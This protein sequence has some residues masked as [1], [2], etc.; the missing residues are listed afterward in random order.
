[1][2]TLALLAACLLPCPFAA[3][4]GGGFTAG[5]LYLFSPAIQGASTAD[6]A[7]VHVDLSAGT[8]TILVDTFTTPSSMGVM[9]FDPWRQ[10]LI[11]RAGLDSVFDPVRLWAVDAAGN[12]DDLGFSG[13]AWSMFAPT[14]D[15]RIYLRNNTGT[16][17]TQPILYL[18]AAN[19]L[20]VL[21]DSTGTAPFLVDGNGAFDIRGIHYD[22]PTNS[23]FISSIAAVGACA[24][25]ATDKLNLRKLPLSADGTR[26]VG[27]VTCVQFEA[28]SFENPVGWSVGP[29]GQPLLVVD[30]NSNAQEPRLVL[31]D[32]TGPSASAFA[33]T[34]SYFGAAATNAGTWCSAL[35]KVVILDT[36]TDVLRAFGAGE[37]GAGTTLVLAGTVSTAGSSGVGVA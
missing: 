20:N 2:R 29:G 13:Q 31:V 27:P 16:A 24:G 12:L 7:L 1:M 3:A 34:G 6:G 4:Q 17:A 15:G 11:F 28:G 22:V 18:D 35:G 32:P 9:C 8:A 25:G 5:D 19:D 30:T 37:T 10:R 26:V 14:G 33:A 23:L 36:G 21:L